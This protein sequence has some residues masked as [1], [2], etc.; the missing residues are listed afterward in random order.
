MIFDA[1]MSIFYNQIA[2]NLMQANNANMNQI[3]QGQAPMAQIS[4][5]EFAAKFQSK[6]ECYHF[7]AYECGVFLPPYGKYHHSD[8][9]ILIP[10]QTT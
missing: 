5:K 9:L 8:S 7:L 6:R 2:E 4:A 3:N 1:V 10:F